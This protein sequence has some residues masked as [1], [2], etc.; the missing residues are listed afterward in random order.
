MNAEQFAQDTHE[1]QHHDI[2]R[3]MAIEPEN[4]LPEQ[5][6]TTRIWRLMRLRVTDRRACR[7]GTTVPSHQPAGGESSTAGG[8]TGASPVDNLWLLALDAPRAG[9]AGP[10]AK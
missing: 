1:R 2:D 8:Q 7:L 9:A 4:V 6:I 3:R 10:A 5:N